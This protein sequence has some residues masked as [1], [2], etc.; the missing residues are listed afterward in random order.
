MTFASQ[1]DVY[2]FGYHYQLPFSPFGAAEGKRATLDLRHQVEA[3]GDHTQG[4]VLTATTVSSEKRS[5]GLVG[6]R[7]R[8][9]SRREWYRS[10]DLFLPRLRPP[11]GKMSTDSFLEVASREAT[12]STAFIV[13]HRCLLAGSLADGTVQAMPGKQ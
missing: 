3:R 12:Y 1:R 10:L 5:T 9:N 11:P 2:H 8:Y 13:S 4:T 7:R 6:P